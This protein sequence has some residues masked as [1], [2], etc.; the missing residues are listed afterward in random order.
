MGSYK[1]CT[2]CPRRCGVNRE[3]GGRGYCGETSALRLG[4][5]GVHHGEEPPVRGAGG[6]GT[7]FVCGCNLGCV[8]C[9]NYQVSQGKK[10]F[11]KSRISCEI[12]RI[13]DTDEFAEIC[14][15]LQ[16]N[17]AE[18]INIVTGSHAAPS[19][20]RGM[21]AARKQGLVIPA[22]WNSS[23]YDGEETLEILKDFVDVYLP[24]LKTLD[25][26]IAARFFNA[27]DYPKHAAQAI[28]KMMELQPPR[29]GPGRG[30]SR[31][32]GVMLSG[33]MIRHLIIPGFLEN[34]RQVLRWYAENCGGRAL[35][36]LMTQY[37]PVRI[38]GVNTGIPNRFV[39]QKEYEAVLSLLDEFAIHDGFCQ[40]LV[41]GANWLPDF[42]QANPFPS[43]L[44]VP[45]WHA[46]TPAGKQNQPQQAH[47]RGQG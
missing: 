10:I 12:S 9:Q 31:T 22:L 34:T 28:L 38:P 24:D 39:S 15:N 43:K 3:S 40:E 5:A 25:P 14:L 33:V 47:Y 16:E 2:L 46:L 19:L 41:T 17:G 44:S 32:S 21:E 18:N 45:V 35:L 23:G 11:E 1:N 30:N 13:V 26:S 29:F 37:T 27:E 7:I 6:S 42:S 8:F 36:S 4:F 20:A